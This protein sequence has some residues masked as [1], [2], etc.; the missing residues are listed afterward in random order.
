MFGVASTAPGYARP[1]SRRPLVQWLVLHTRRGRLRRYARAMD[2]ALSSDGVLVGD[3]FV[4][5]I[6]GFFDLH[7]LRGGG[8]YGRLL[9]LGLGPGLEP[10]D[11]AIGHRLGCEE[12]RG[13]LLSL[14][15]ELEGGTT[16][17]PW[18]VRLE[19]S[20]RIQWE[21]SQLVGFSLRRHRRRLR[22]LAQP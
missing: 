1:L 10:G 9:S 17:L 15:D 4:V 13:L 18:H 5:G 11:Q 12:F 2:W 7:A 20:S 14:G 16:A 6:L 22:R 3:V 19:R 21:L 8:G